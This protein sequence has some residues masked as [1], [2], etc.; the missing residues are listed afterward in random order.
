MSHLST[1]DLVFLSV[2]YVA[3]PTETPASMGPDLM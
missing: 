3:R 2:V 1:D